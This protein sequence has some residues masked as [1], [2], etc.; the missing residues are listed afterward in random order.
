[1]SCPITHTIDLLG[2]LADLRTKPELIRVVR[3]VDIEEIIR[4]TC[5]RIH[6]L[7]GIRYVDLLT[8]TRRLAES[9]PC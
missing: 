2:F 3:D 9:D 7:T 8:T 5:R 1:M 6:E 4:W